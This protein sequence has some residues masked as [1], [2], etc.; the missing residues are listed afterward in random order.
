MS[1]KCE[2]PIDELTVKVWLQFCITT[3][4]FII[5]LY[6]GAKL[7]TDKWTDRQRIEQYDYQMPRMDLLGRD[8]N[9]HVNF[10][11]RLTWHCL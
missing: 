1:V 10:S 4:T 11:I 9:I 3:K 8:L 6:V 7:K 5:A 2:Q